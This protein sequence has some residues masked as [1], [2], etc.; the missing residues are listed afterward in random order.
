M[1]LSS[2]TDA[3]DRHRSLWEEQIGV[4]CVLAV[5]ARRSQGEPAAIDPRVWQL[6]GQVHRQTGDRA[7]TE[8]QVPDCSMIDWQQVIERGR[9]Q[10]NKGDRQ[11][12]IKRHRQQ[13]IERH[14]QQAIERHRQ[15]V[16]TGDQ[17]RL[18]AAGEDDRRLS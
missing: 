8:R 14:R 16:P 17:E 13:A 2:S 18:T 6:K 5:D 7:A 15:Q 12:V 9:Q 4:G 11:Q 10:V 3:D 1:G